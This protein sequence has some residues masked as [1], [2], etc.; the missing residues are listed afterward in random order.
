MI[1]EYKIFYIPKG[2]GRFR[3]IYEP[4]G[5]YKKRLIKANKKIA[6]IVKN[7]DFLQ[8]NHAFIKNRN[9][10]TNAERHKNYSYTLSMDLTDFFDSVDKKLVSKYLKDEF[11]ELCFIDGY[12]RQGLPT[13]PA[14]ANLSLLQTDRQIYN[15]LR[16]LNLNIIYTRYADDLTVSFNDISY[17]PLIKKILKSNIQAVG[18][19]FNESKTKLQKETNGRRI[20][21]GVGVDRS[22]VYPTRKIKKKIRAAKHQDNLDSLRGLEEWAKCKRPNNR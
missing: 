10:I 22:G 5:D 17:L 21:T 8:I 1:Q 2:N 3:R 6:L 18:F 12:L 7:Y 14:I 11:M 4:L 9:C 20:I 19:T 16:E 13:S 15:R